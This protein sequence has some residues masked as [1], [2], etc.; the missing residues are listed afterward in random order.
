MNFV[1][2]GV[3]S[4]VAQAK[5]AAGDKSVAIASPSIAQQCLSL[6]LLDGISVNVIPVLLGGGIP[7]FANV[8][9]TPIRLSGPD[10][11]EGDGVTHL[12]YRVE[13]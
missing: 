3:E 11:V 4:A 7:L 6:G 12:N 9:E 10:I 13:R 1:L 8:A 5:R 2:D